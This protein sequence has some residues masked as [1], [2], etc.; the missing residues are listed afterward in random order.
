MPATQKPPASHHRTYRTTHHRIQY[1]LHTFSSAWARRSYQGPAGWPAQA[2]PA[3]HSSGAIGQ[4]D[5][6]VEDLESRRTVTEKLKKARFAANNNSRDL[7]TVRNHA[8]YGPVSGKYNSW[9]LGGWFWRSFVATYKLYLLQTVW[10]ALCAAM[11]L[12]YH[13]PNASWLRRYLENIP[14]EE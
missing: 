14:Q 3:I 8:F 4:I 10:T 2:I 7:S 13:Y 6:R 12:W 1:S 11:H 9:L 5:Q